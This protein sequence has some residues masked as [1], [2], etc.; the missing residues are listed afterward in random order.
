MYMMIHYRATA[1]L[2]FACLTLAFVCA[3]HGWGHG[4]LLFASHAHASEGANCARKTEMVL[5]KGGRVRMGNRHGYREEAPERTKTIHSFWLS[6]QEVRNEEFAQFVE[7]TNYKTT[8]EI[9]WDHHKYPWLAESADIPGSVVFK[10]PAS[11]GKG[12]GIASTGQSW[13]QFVAGASWRQPEGPGSHLKGR[14]HHP[15]VHI[16]WEDAEAYARWK[17]ARLPT[18][19]EW[20]YAAR[21]AKDVDAKP[22]VSAPAPKNANTWQGTFPHHNTAEDGYEG[23]A[24]SGCYKPNALGLYDMLG[25]VWEWTASWYYP[26]HGKHTQKKGL[27]PRQPGVPVRVIKGGSYLCS[28]DHCARYRPSARQAQEIALGA[29]HI[30]FRIAMNVT[31]ASST[32]P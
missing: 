22:H 21:G 10:A 32:T 15:V 3:F 26:S 12:K 8:A 29:S 14:E 20:E 5:V 17:G 28:S 25:N 4:T 2:V 13:W 18:E 11:L 7:R 9:G 19:E 23:T 31:E 27:D 30:G 1:Y 24:P 16:S 6:N